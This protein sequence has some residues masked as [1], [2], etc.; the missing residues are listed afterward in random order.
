M[1]TYDVATG[2][3][4]MTERAAQIV[5]E[6]PDSFGRDK[7]AYSA[8]VHPDDLPH[9]LAT[10]D[11]RL[12]GKE[13]SAVSQYRL[14][15]K[16][17]RWVWLTS[18]AKTVERDNEGRAL[19]VVGMLQDISTQKAIEIALARSEAQLRAVIDAVPLGIV[20]VDSMSE[21]LVVNQACL[22]MLGAPSANTIIGQPLSHY[23]DLDE[24]AP[25]RTT[26][27]R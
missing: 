27:L 18:R 25:G 22:E 14:S 1:W 13:P 20:V 21:I 12:S 15:H 11:D 19:R 17:G 16:D 10:R 8:R 4:E 3:F 5:G 6:T 26:R 9:F 7:Q 23:L 2:Q 24:A